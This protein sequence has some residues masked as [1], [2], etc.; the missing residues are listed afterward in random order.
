MFK[1]IIRSGHFLTYI[2][3]LL[4]LVRRKRL[5]DV[6]Q[7]GDEHYCTISDDCIAYLDDVSQNNKLPGRAEIARITSYYNITRAVHNT[8]L[9]T[10]S[11]VPLA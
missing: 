9:H 6:I 5:R 4:L 2:I 8:R 11:C 1:S 10:Y 7:I 3:L